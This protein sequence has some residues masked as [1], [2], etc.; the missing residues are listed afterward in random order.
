[1]PRGDEPRIESSL[2][3]IIRRRRMTRR[4]DGGP[5]VA[6]V[7]AVA[8]LARRAPSAGFAQGTHL[9]VMTGDDLEEFWTSSG[10]GTWFAD[11][12]TGVLEARHVILIFAD[13]QAYLDRYS[14]DDK[15]SL[16][17]GDAQ[18]WS[19]PYWLVDAGMVAQNLL[20]L[21]EERRWGALFFG[22]DGMR[23]EY[24]A[25]RGVPSTAQCI[26][27]VAVG[28]RAEDDR[29]SGS[30]VTRSRLDTSHVVHIGRWG[31]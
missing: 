7:V 21:I 20:L 30:A 15:A 16:G 13:R 23:T 27:A 8:D 9:L 31:S 10:A 3:D 4:F 28:F 25:Q 19:V 18:R 17:L 26:G 11:R 29:A 24:L 22:V 1:M 6:D 2:I 12:S 5:E 14:M